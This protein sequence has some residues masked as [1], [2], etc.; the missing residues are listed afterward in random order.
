MKNKGRCRYDGQ[1]TSLKTDCIDFH[2]ICIRR[3][4]K[5]REAI[6]ANHQILYI[7]P[8]DEFHVTA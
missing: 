5:M 6:T 7:F 1:F 8:K 4:L 3:K 2:V